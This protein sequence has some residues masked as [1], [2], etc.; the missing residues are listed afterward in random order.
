MN[1]CTP[2]VE[3]MS[4]LFNSHVCRLQKFADLHNSCLVQANIH[5]LR[6]GSR[7][8]LIEPFGASKRVSGRKSSKGFILTALISIEA[9]GLI[10]SSQNKSNSLIWLMSFISL[11]CFQSKDW[12]LAKTITQKF[13]LKNEPPKI[14]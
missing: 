13:M 7:I 12:C 2:S 11:T 5:P 10:K 8:V 3:K 1:H 4:S 6:D 14:I 9:L